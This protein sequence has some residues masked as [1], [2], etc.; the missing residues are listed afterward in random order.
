MLSVESSTQAAPV[1]TSSASVSVKAGESFTHQIVATNTPTSYTAQNLPAGLGLDTSS[2]LISGSIATA[3]NYTAT[4]QVGNSGGN[5]IQALS[6][7]ISEG[8]QTP[9]P[10]PT[11]TPAPA[12]QPS[13]GGTAPSGGGSPPAEKAKKGSKGKTSSAKKAGSGSKKSLAS[14]SSGGK[15]SGAKN[16][17][18][19]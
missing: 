12:P 17:N 3:G 13:S 4:I 16:G 10:T 5:G 7:V 14:K 8:R 18:K 6:I 15:K 1:I 2:G 11:P 9:E 19:K